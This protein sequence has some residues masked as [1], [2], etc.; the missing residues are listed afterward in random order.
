[1]VGNIMIDTLIKHKEDAINTNYFKTLGLSPKEYTVVTLHRPSNVDT[2][3]AL[4]PILEAL[5]EIA[6]QSTVIFSMHP[7]TQQKIDVFGLNEL[8]N[9]DGIKLNQVNAIGPKP[10]F[11]MLNLTMH[12]QCVITDSGG[13][14]EETTVMGVPCLTLR[15]NTERPV[16]IK[17][18]TNQL[19]K[20]E[21]EIILN[22]FNNAINRKGGFETPKFWDGKTAERIV[23]DL[24]S[25]LS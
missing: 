22:A 8:V 23:K 6:K 16:T 20:Q 13:L 18:G 24:I 4:T 1:M 10:Y 17:H 9:M 2:K 11:D 3:E 25:W 7:R 15:N 12:A 5:N 21:K 19:V 14:Q